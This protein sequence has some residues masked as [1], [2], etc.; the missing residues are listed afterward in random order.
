[1]EHFTKIRDMVTSETGWVR[2]K[3]TRRGLHPTRSERMFTLWLEGK[4][5]FGDVDDGNDVV[6]NKNGHEYHDNLISCSWREKRA[7]SF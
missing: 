1:M 7:V 2:Q 6:D 3:T 5:I 4:I